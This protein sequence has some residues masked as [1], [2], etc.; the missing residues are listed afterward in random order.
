VGY[1]VDWTAKATEKRFRQPFDS[2]FELRLSLCLQQNDYPRVALAEGTQA[3]GRENQKIGGIGGSGHRMI[4][5]HRS[6][7]ESRRE[8][9]VTIRNDFSVV[10]RSQTGHNRAAILSRPRK[11]NFLEFS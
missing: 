2:P 11:I 9:G 7:L 3:E 10:S 5:N 4:V 1:L 8:T 6:E